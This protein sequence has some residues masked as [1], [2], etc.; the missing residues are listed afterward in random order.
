M[1]NYLSQFSPKLAALAVPLNTISG[2]RSEW[3]WGADQEQAFESNKVTLTNSPVLCV[4]DLDKKHRI[5]ADS[6]QLA[7]GAALLQLN[8]NGDWQPVEYASRKL[9]ETETRYAMVEKEALAVTWA[10]E[11]FDYYLVG[12]KF[13][14][15]TD[16]KSLIEIL[17]SKDLSL[18]PLRVQRFKM[19]MMRYDYTIF[20]TPGAKMFIAD[21]LSRPTELGSTDECML[22]CNVVECYVSASVTE[23]E[24]NSF[25]EGEL[26]RALESD[27]ASCACL[28]YMS[29]GWPKSG[30]GLSGE[31]HKLFTCKDRLTEYGGL[32]MYDARLYVPSTMREQYMQR[33]HG[34]HQGIE[35]CRR[36]FRESV[37]WP[38]I[39]GD[40]EKFVTECETCIK[41]RAVKHQPVVD[42]PL[43]HGPWSEVG[44]DVFY[45]DD[46]LYLVVVDYYS[47]WIEAVYIAAQT[48][49]KVVEALKDV[50]ARY[51]VPGKL[52]S[53]NGPCFNSGCFSEF[54]RMWGFKHVTSS[55]HYPQSNG[56]AERAVGT[57][58]SLWRKTPDHASAMLAY[59]TTPIASGYSPGEL[60]FGRSI[61]SELRG[62]EQGFCGLRLL[63]GEGEEVQ[64]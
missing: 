5:T 51:G 24:R 31:L 34:G 40:I 12:R 56:M 46:K 64:G 60:M 45:F 28:G 62:G 8:S 4:F 9:T 35:K 19:R 38:G 15:E 50:F 47:R 23:N 20:H 54:V 55:P 59:R 2:S 58:K 63:R 57:V 1:V 41:H 7:V 27:C 61:R 36:R 18:L 29:E 48:S 33:C 11:K 44:T 13:E 30:K 22:Q 3:V 6:S 17:G 52:R 16:H 49:D 43:P 39:N 42:N 10:C 25:R 14:I 53:D 21:L 32:I 26:L 37:W